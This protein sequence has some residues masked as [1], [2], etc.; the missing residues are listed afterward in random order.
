MNL[1]EICI[2]CIKN[3]AKF[4]TLEGLLLIYS[5][6]DSGNPTF[7]NIRGYAIRNLSERYPM[8]YDR[9]GEEEMRLIF[10]PEDFERFEKERLSSL[11][12]KN[13]FAYLKG[14]ILEPIAKDVK[15]TEEGFYPL[16]VLVQGAAWP[17]NIDPTKRE[18]YLS[19]NDF[20]AVFKMS[21]S[22]YLSKD[23]H[24]RLRLKKEYKLF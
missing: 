15:A 5:K 1:A 8:L 14:S 9:Y 20:H 17:T 2:S 6:L 7:L 22:E 19:E 23:R 24:V 3:S 16:E 12:I 11:E 21:K 13:R 18:T 10:S 4:K